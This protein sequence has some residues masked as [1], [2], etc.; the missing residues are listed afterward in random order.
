MIDRIETRKNLARRERYVYHLVHP[1]KLI[2]DSKESLGMYELGDKNKMPVA[3]TPPISVH[4]HFSIAASLV[5]RSL[6]TS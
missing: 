2:T 3:S 4:E 5:F 6:T 1:A